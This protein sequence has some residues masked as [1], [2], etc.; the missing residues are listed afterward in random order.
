[1]ASVDGE[2]VHNELDAIKTPIGYI[3]RYEDLR[4]YSGRF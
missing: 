3:P 2:E 1:M 4:A